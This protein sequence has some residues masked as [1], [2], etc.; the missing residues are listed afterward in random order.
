[1]TFALHSA[2]RETSTAPGTS[3]FTLN[4]ALDSSYFAFSDVYSDGDTLHYVAKGEAGREVGVGTFNTLTGPVYT[5]SRSVIK[6]T[7][8]D[9]AVNFS[10]G[11]VDIAVTNV[12]PSAL[13]SSQLV[14]MATAYGAVAFHASQT[15]TDTQKKQILTNF[16]GLFWET[17]HIRGTIR[18]TASLGWVMMDDTT[19]GDS[20]S[21]A[22]HTGGDYQD[23]FSLLFNNITDTYAPLLTSAGG[24]TTRAAQTNA[25][26]AWAAHCRISLLKTLGRVVGASGSGSGLTARTLGQTYGVE[27]HAL[28]SNEMPS[29]TLTFTGTGTTIGSGIQLLE[30]SGVQGTSGILGYLGNINSSGFSYT[31]SG[32]I[33]PFGSGSVHENMQPTVFINWEIKL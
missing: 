28:L 15:L 9:S 22:T 4:G 17:G 29:T 10:A 18:T 7:S 25:A 24:A 13:S 1:M 27:T 21:G 33:S 8:A 26:T 23:L 14:T 19:I 20:S 2:V 5:L 3:A 11:T 6:S 30:S 16:G 12:G 31:P 32:S